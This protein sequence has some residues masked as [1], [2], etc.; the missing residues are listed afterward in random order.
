MPL[1][2]LGHTVHIEGIRCFPFPTGKG[3]TV[4][5][6][7]GGDWRLER[8][9]E[10]GAQ[11]LRLYGHLSPP[12]RERPPPRKKEPGTP[13]P[14]ARGRAQEETPKG[15]PRSPNTGHSNPHAPSPPRKGPPREVRAN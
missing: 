5:T 6:F 10:G 13:K 1:D 8:P 7:S 12:G 15:A 9:R 4:K 2:V 3:K 11:E 14:A